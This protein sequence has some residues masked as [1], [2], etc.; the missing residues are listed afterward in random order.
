MNEYRKYRAAGDWDGKP[1]NTR[2]IEMYGYVRTL[3]LA[4]VLSMEHARTP[5]TRPLRPCA[6]APKLLALMLQSTVTP[7][8]A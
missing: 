2:S 4:P 8:E 7:A 5:L 1:Q 3:L 6:F